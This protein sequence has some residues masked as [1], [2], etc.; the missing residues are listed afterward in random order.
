MKSR[1]KTRSMIKIIRTNIQNSLINSREKI[2][3]E[4]RKEE[5]QE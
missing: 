4:A 3:K 2:G 5:K 1:M